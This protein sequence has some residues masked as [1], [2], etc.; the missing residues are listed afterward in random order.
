MSSLTLLTETVNAEYGASGIPKAGFPSGTSSGWGVTIETFDHA[1]S[2]AGVSNRSCSAQVDLTRREFG[3][4][5]LNDVQSRIC[6]TSV[7]FLEDAHSAKRRLSFYGN[8]ERSCP[9]AER[10]NLALLVDEQGGRTLP[11]D[12][13][14]PGRVIDSVSIVRLR[15][16]LDRVEFVLLDDRRLFLQFVDLVRIRF[17]AAVP[18]RIARDFLVELFD[19]FLLQPKRR[20]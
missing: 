6:G 16:L 8:A 19:H 4:N 11:S 5:S 7:A 12:P 14:R 9:S 20:R 13:R 15:T 10:V 17:S 2:S 1:G 18:R 3:V